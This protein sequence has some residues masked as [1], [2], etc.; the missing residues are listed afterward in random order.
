MPAKLPKIDLPR[1]LR[2]DWIAIASLVVGVVFIAANLAIGLKK[3]VGEPFPSAWTGVFVF[4]QL[5]VACG[6]LMLLG[7]TAKEGTGWG[8]AA[9]LLAMIVGISGVLLAAALWA[10]A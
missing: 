9:S 5:A 8:N 4:G 7:K 2:W 1:P 10:A 3:P 6:G